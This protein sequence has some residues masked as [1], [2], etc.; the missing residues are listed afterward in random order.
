MEVGSRRYGILASSSAGRLRPYGIEVSA[1]FR[2]AVD[3]PMWFTGPRDDY[4]SCYSLETAATEFEVQGLE[5]DWPL[6]AWSWDLLLSSSGITYQNL[7]GVHWR[8]IADPAKRD[9]LANKYRVLLTRAREGM[10]LFLPKGSRFDE[11]R[12][13]ASMNQVEEFFYACGA[14]PLSDFVKP[15]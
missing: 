14:V 8:T 5:L 1:D 9:Y 13:P 10:V 2:K 7:R 3:Y 6:V 4:R 15:I 12:D 11:T